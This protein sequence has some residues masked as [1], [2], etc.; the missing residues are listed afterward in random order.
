MPQTIT[1]HVATAGAVKAADEAEASKISSTRF[2]VKFVEFDAPLSPSR[3]KLAVALNGPGP[4]AN[5][6][7]GDKVID[8]GSCVLRIRQPNPVAGFRIVNATGTTG[9]GAL[10]YTGAR[11][12]GDDPVESVMR[13]KVGV[14]RSPG[15]G[16]AQVS[17]A[18]QL[19][20][21]NGIASP[22]GVGLVGVS[23]FDTPPVDSSH[24]L[25]I[26]A[27]ATAMRKGQPV[28]LR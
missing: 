9:D 22:G 24:A 16:I 4:S 20:S 26:K 21:E 5:P 27:T 8:D 13:S 25:E 3:R 14:G 2:C 19:L 23:A 17:V 28:G 1:L 10:R 12:E 15:A 11:H 18:V 7:D 6:N